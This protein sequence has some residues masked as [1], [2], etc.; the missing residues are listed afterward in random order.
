SG[1][2]P[3]NDTLRRHAR[4]IWQAAV[5][6]VRPEPLVCQALAD[7]HLAQVLHAAPRI[8]V[9]GAGKAGA[10]MAAATEDALA[11]VL[12]RVEGIVNV[13]AESVRPLRRIGLHAARPAGSN[14]P[15][16]D[17]VAGALDMLRL[18]REG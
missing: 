10:A 7:P 6:A 1:F 11:D 4:E 15:T 5:D 14:Q 13:P 16:A 2:T 3:M 12:D 8:L 9:M 17:G 18:A